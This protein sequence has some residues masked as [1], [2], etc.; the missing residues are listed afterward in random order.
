MKHP[1]PKSY[2]KNKKKGRKEFEENFLVLVI[3]PQLVW[4]NSH[5]K[6]TEKNLGKKE[7]TTTWKQQKRQ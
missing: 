3:A 4:T 6:T 5:N 7:V 1:E 2:L